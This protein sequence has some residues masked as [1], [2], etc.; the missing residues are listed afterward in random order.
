MT[1]IQFPGT[2]I[3]DHVYDPFDLSDYE[4]FGIIP[5]R[6][7]LRTHHYAPPSARA[8]TWQDILADV[9]EDNKLGC[10]DRYRASAW[11]KRCTC[12]NSPGPI[13]GTVCWANF[14]VIA[15]SIVNNWLIA[16]QVRDLQLHLAYKAAPV[17]RLVTE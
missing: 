6:E 10:F 8:F 3:P 9:E 17:L 4:T 14:M 16:S 1:V 5:P 7:T 15:K 12:H 2:H 11:H 13:A